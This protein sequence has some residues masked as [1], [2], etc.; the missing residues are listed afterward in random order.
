MFAPRLNASQLSRQSGVH[1]SL[2][3]KR[4][5][6]ESD[7]HVAAVHRPQWDFGGISVFGGESQAE[8]ARGGPEAKGKPL[9]WNQRADAGAGSGSGSGGGSGSGSGVAPAATPV[10][11]RNGPHHAPFDIFVDHDERVGMEIAITLT[12]STGKDEDMES[13]LDSEQVSDP[14]GQTGSFIGMPKDQT[15]TKWM[16]G[17]PI[18]DD[19]HGISRDVVI[20]R[21]DDHGGDG[22]YDIDQ[23]DIFKRK[24]GDAPQVIPHSGY[25][26]RRTI[27]TGA[28][29]SIVLRT[30]KFPNACSV[31]GF[32]SE[33]GPSPAQHDDVTVRAAAH[34]SGSG[35]G[36]GG[37]SGS[38]S[39][40]GSRR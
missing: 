12:S 37:G 36:S 6:H 33:K 31:N 4:S 9:A 14:K 34:G 29:K 26:V 2:A 18:P 8:N 10:A 15:T 7:R 22:K 30:E 39:G 16:K 21:A 35:S 23:L 17:Y 19:E 1:S 32:S 25:T 13:I 40:S 3:V 24:D 27:T 11:V 5:P 20:D 28:G 38:G